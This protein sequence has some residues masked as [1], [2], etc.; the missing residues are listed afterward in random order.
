MENKDF[1]EEYKNKQVRKAIK[2]KKRQ[3]NVIKK[4]NF[5]TL[6]L[7]LNILSIVFII[8]SSISILSF[9]S[10]KEI[11]PSDIESIN[12]NINS[13]DKS[14][15]LKEQV[16]E[17]AYWSYLVENTDNLIFISSLV[18]VISFLAL[19]FFN[20]IFKNKKEKK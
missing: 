13:L 9:Y 1:L 20:L 2:K 4:A 15:H 10:F 16:P 17:L 6:K 18:L 7:V 19:I 11:I 8:I 3:Q 5:K 14:I 12:K